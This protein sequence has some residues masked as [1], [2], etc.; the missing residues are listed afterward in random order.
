MT[1]RQDG[2]SGEVRVSPPEITVEFARYTAADPLCCPSSRVDVRFR[3]DRTP[4]GP[5]VV[6]VA[7]QGGVRQ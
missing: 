6:P 3:I 7:I 2:S 5:T 4:P 1:S